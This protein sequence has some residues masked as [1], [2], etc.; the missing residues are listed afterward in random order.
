MEVNNVKSVSGL[1]LL[2]FPTI[3]LSV[4]FAIL[5][6]FS[7]YWISFFCFLFFIPIHF[8]S[9]CWLCSCHSKSLT[10]TSLNPQLWSNWSTEGLG[11]VNVPCAPSFYPASSGKIYKLFWQLVQWTSSNYSPRQYLSLYCASWDVDN[12]ITRGGGG[13]GGNLYYVLESSDPFQ[14]RDS[15]ILGFMSRFYTDRISVI[16]FCAQYFS[17]LDLE[18]RCSPLRRGQTMCKVFRYLICSSP[19]ISNVFE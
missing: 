11:Q 1:N 18:N 9:L 8:T 16:S 2:V 14:L 6:F 5:F 7:D 19:E 3:Y 4:A 13:D 15:P 10:C 17:A 12:G